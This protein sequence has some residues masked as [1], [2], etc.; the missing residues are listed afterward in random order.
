[1]KIAIVIICLI[2]SSL[3]M[4]VSV[5]MNWRFGL[6]LGR[7]ELDSHI[8]G[9]ASIGA[10][11]LKA[12][13]PFLIAWGWR[14]KHYIGSGFASVIL[15]VTVCY[16]ITSSVGFAS[17]NRA[18]IVGKRQVTLEKYNALKKEKASLLKTSNNLGA[19]LPVNE[20]KSRLRALEQNKRWSSSQKCTNS[21]VKA[22]REFCK[23]YFSLEAD[24]G[25]AREKQEIKTRLSE[26]KRDLKTSPSILENTD[27]Q[28]LELSNLTGA[29]IEVVKTSLIILVAMLVEL[30]STFGFYISLNHG[31]IKRKEKNTE[32]INETMELVE[33]QDSSQKESIENY[34]Y[35]RVFQ[36]QGTYI[37]LPE[38]YGDYAS[39]CASHSVRESSYGAFQGAFS[40]LSKDVGIP[41]KM[42]DEGVLVFA[43]IRLGRPELK[44]NEN[45]LI[46]VA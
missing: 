22:S 35:N 28:A 10:D 23:N 24:L 29:K 25:R 40:K 46:E 8:Y 6:T 17:L 26:I 34:V 38:I 31:E 42:T 41:N 32:I 19:T 3:L 7:T 4:L 13:S 5:A 45:K 2:A 11:C 43:N 1:M 15:L 20:V 27:P 12:F 39:W 21:T 33:I 14:N 30:G 36:E 37:T 9:L 18:E 44:I 16:S